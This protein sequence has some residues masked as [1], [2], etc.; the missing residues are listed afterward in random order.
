[1]R[2]ASLSTSPAT[3]IPGT[4]AGCAQHSFRAA[5]PWHRAEAAKC[6][7]GEMRFG[8]GGLGE[9]SASAGRELFQPRPRLGVHAGQR[10]LHQ[11]PGFEA[12]FSAHR[13][14]GEVGDG[15]V[16]KP[17]C[18][19]VPLLWPKV[20]RATAKAKRSL[21]FCGVGS[22]TTLGTG[23]GGR[24]ARER[25][26]QAAARLFYQKGIRSTGIAALTEAAHVS[27]RTFYQH[28]AS[29]NALVE[30]YL[31]RYEAETP[32]PSELQLGRADLT[33]R[34]RLLAI[35]DPIEPAAGNVVRG[36]PFHNAAVEAAGEMPGVA[37]LVEK[38]KRAFRDLLITIAAEAGAADPT[39][40]GRQ[41]A[42]IYEGA[43]ALSAS[44]N[45]A[46]VIDDARHAAATVIRAA[47]G[48]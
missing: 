21:Y 32:I 22:T 19:G 18:S 46:L 13:R 31:S 48:D 2:S 30:A 43:A 42:V 9:E 24:G 28:F 6:L 29:K 5:G 45:D 10:E 26:L 38:H 7:H 25:I 34:E 20:T 17:W 27:T 8:V 40:L 47:L 14:G 12:P 23:R 16:E 4:Y 3:S 44:C 33:A 1:M 11:G 15:Q 39:S 41:L 37:H 36:C 35:F